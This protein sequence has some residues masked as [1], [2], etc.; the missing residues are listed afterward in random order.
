VCGK[1]INST[2]KSAPV[3][4]GPDQARHR[5]EAAR[6]EAGEQATVSNGADGKAQT[7]SLLFK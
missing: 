1:K 4:T 5:D 6:R 2:Q 7:Q 3:Y